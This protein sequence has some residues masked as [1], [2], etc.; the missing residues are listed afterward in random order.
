M[1][2][3]H[4]CKSGDVSTSGAVAICT[5]GAEFQAPSIHSVVQ[6]IAIHADE[7]NTRDGVANA[8]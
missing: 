5:C 7:A 3:E 8:S 2:R 4:Q 1:N 6:A